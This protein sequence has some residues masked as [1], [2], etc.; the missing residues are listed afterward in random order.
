[1]TVREAILDFWDLSGHVSDLYPFLNDTQGST[2]IDINAEGT[3]YF[4]RLLSQGQIALANWKKRD[5]RF[6]RF[7]N[8]YISTN[9]QLGIDPDIEYEITRVSETEY[10]VDPTQTSWALDIET[11]RNSVLVVEASKYKV[12][13]A[14]VVSP[15][16]WTFYVY[17]IP[18]ETID[19]VYPETISEVQFG[20]NEFDIET[21]ALPPANTYQLTLPERVYSILRIDDFQNNLEILRADNKEDLATKGEATNTGSPG[22]YLDLGS[23]I[24]FNT[25]LLEKRWYKFELFQ[26]PVDITALDATLAIPTPFHQALI[27]WGMWK[28]SLRERKDILATNYRRLID[29]ELLATRDE[30]DNDFERTKTFNF[31]VRRS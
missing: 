24:V 17:P 28:I 3:Q 16:N 11:F 10:Q 14:T 7:R 13:S 12:M 29:N 27:F 31:R 25:A 20:I 26:Q 15:T 6:L 22:Y 8:F 18:A 1:M 21:S 4:L 2:D 9:I 30:Y 19:V 23:K 5:Q